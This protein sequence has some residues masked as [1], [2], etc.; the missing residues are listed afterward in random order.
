MLQGAPYRIL[1]LTIIAG[2]QTYFSIGGCQIKN[3][4]AFYFSIRLYDSQIIK[5]Q[6]DDLNGESYILC[7]AFQFTQDT[8]PINTTT[9]SDDRT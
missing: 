9:G 7:Y 4:F 6:N 5:R 1:L 8:P 3:L 2:I